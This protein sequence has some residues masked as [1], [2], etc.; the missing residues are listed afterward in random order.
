MVNF[1]G[2]FSTGYYKIVPP[3]RDLGGV[4]FPSRATHAPIGSVGDFLSIEMP[5]YAAPTVY[6]SKLRRKRGPHQ[7]GTRQNP[8][9]FGLS[10]HRDEALHVSLLSWRHHIINTIRIGWSAV[11]ATE[12][13]GQP[14]ALGR[15]PARATTYGMH[16]QTRAQEA[17]QARAWA[18]R[19]ST[20]YQTCRPDH[21]PYNF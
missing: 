15:P 21:W 5:P 11:S 19:P 2:P 18:E 1:R 6:R 17:L 13:P 8:T 14:W 16:F 7:M 20:L 12:S 4:R 10:D 3:R 9:N